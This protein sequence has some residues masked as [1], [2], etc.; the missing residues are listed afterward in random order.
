[1]VGIL[2]M[3]RSSWY[4]TAAPGAH[5]RTYGYTSFRD[6]IVADVIVATGCGITLVRA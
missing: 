1:M 2:V 6:V 4:A 5:S 3:V